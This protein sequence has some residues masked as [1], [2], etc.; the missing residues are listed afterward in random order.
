MAGRCR[1]RRQ[2]VGVCRSHGCRDQINT[3]VSDTRLRITVDAIE[4]DPDE[5]KQIFASFSVATILLDSSTQAGTSRLESLAQ[6]WGNKLRVSVVPV[7][8]AIEAS[9]EQRCT[10]SIRLVGRRQGVLGAPHVLLGRAK[11]R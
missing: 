8:G 3:W 10:L 11:E 5:P 6:P 9:G 2:H 1:H 7:Q 4:L